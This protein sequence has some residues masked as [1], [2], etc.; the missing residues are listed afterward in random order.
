MVPPAGQLG[1]GPATFLRR[2]PVRIVNGQAVDGYT[3]VFEIICRAC[4]DHPGLD[5]IEVIPRAASAPRALSAEAGIAAYERH[6]GLTS[7][8]S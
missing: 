2:R 5:Y 4:G 1:H 8:A 6:I 7:W 3:D